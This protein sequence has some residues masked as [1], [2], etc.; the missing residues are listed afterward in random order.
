MLFDSSLVLF[1]SSFQGR[2][3]K[4]GVLKNFANFTGENLCRSLFWRLATLLKRDPSTGFAVQFAKFLRT[5][6]LKSIYVRLLLASYMKMVFNKTRLILLTFNH[7]LL[8]ILTKFKLV[9]LSHVIHLRSAF[10]CRKECC[11]R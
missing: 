6:I 2:S 1:R 5:P 4:I 7:Q 10:C 8:T 9:F 3:L 11:H